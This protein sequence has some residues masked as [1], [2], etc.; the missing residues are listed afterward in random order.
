MISRKR[1]C[2]VSGVFLLT[3]LFCLAS[4][5]ALATE[6]QVTVDI[7]GSTSIPAPTSYTFDT[8]TPFSSSDST[9]TNLSVNWDSDCGNQC[10]VDWVTYNS[11]GSDIVFNFQNTQIDWTIGCLDVVNTGICGVPSNGQPLNISAVGVT[12]GSYGVGGTITVNY[13]PGN[14]S[15]NGAP[16]VPE[17]AAYLELFGTVLLLA[18]LA[19]RR[20]SPTKCGL[21]RSRW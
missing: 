12:Y 15:N 4:I 9:I 6:Y 1:T 18:G 16:G 11:A 7:M 19:Y 20:F 2:P 8:T 3:A 5:P 21:A 13:A 17:P 14:G 10:S